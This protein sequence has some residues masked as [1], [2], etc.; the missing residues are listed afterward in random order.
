MSRSILVVVVSLTV[1]LAACFSGLGET[2]S[3]ACSGYIGEAAI[4]V[5]LDPTASYFS[6]DIAGATTLVVVYGEGELSASGT[7]NAIPAQ[8]VVEETLSLPV[9]QTP[10]D[11]SV[12]SW[13]PAW[14]VTAPSPYTGTLRLGTATTSR[15]AGQLVYDFADSTQLTCSFDLHRSAYAGGDSVGWEIQ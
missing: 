8:L 2:D 6:E 9:S 1:P 7:L 12:L 10:A 5:S 13:S 14:S 3:G 15:L 11:G 4:D